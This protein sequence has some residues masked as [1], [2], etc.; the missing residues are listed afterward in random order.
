MVSNL[1]LGSDLLTLY[2]YA[3]LMISKYFS[4]PKL[5]KISSSRPAYN[6]FG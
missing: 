5:D 6:F 2:S 4:S 3:N 1:T